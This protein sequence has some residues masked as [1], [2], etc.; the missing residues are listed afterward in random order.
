MK[1]ESLLSV[2]DQCLRR[3]K[4][5]NGPCVFYICCADMVGVWGGATGWKCGTASAFLVAAAILVEM[6]GRCG[7]VP[8]S[9]SLRRATEAP[10]PP[11][12]AGSLFRGAAPV[13][14]LGL[15]GRV[16]S[17]GSASLPHPPSLRTGHPPQRMRAIARGR[18]GGCSRPKP[19][20]CIGWPLAAPP[21]RDI[22]HPLRVRG[23]GTSAHTGIG[24]V[25]T[26]IF[27]FAEDAEEGDPRFRRPS[28]AVSSDSENRLQPLSP[29]VRT[30][31]APLTQGSLD[32]LP[33]ESGRTQIPYISTNVRQRT[34]EQGAF[35][36]ST[37]ARNPLVEGARGSRG[38]SPLALFSTG[39]PAHFLSHRKW[40]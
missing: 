35:Y 33:I 26:G 27:N 7:M 22:A 29:S 9:Y 4:Y 23:G 32:R 3:C 8:R 28:P 6:Y 11:A 36:I 16:G 14:T 10:V 37:L 30:G 21:L 12:G 38:P 18:D 1:R 2:L 17:I 19:P 34:E 24:R 25:V 20:L 40:G 15:R 5:G 39:A 31:T 13:R